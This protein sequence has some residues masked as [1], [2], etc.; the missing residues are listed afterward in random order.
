MQ[1]FLKF[2][3][4]PANHYQ[5]L[6][7]HLWALY[8]FKPTILCSWL[9]MPLDQFF[10]NAGMLDCLACGQNGTSM[11]KPVRNWIKET[12]SG[13]KMLQYWIEMR[14]AG[15]S[16]LAASTWMPMPS[17]AW[18]YTVLLTVIIKITSHIFSRVFTLVDPSLLFCYRPSKPKTY[19]T[20]LWALLSIDVHT[21]QPRHFGLWGRGFNSYTIYLC[22]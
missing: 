10:L 9:A 3:S 2:L 22:T 20:Y 17:Y 7:S 13:T 14:D 12:Q 8:D 19:S 1:P 21:F 4:R 16:M 6:A 5:L 15:M 11:P 18:T